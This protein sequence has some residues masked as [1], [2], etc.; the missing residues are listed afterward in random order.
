[1]FIESDFVYVVYWFVRRY[2]FYFVEVCVIFIIIIN[3]YKY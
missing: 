1:M 2:I 3:N